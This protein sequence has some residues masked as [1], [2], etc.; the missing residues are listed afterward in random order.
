[1][2]SSVRKGMQGVKAFCEEKA[3]AGAEAS[4]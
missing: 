2:T 4:P 3:R 1:M